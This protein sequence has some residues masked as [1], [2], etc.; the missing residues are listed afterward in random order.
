MTITSAHSG[1]A[2]S[3]EA[4]AELLQRL[5]GAAPKV[6]VFFAGVAHDGAVL[7]RALEQRF[8]D[9][10]VIGCSTNGEFATNHFGK[11]GAVALAIGAGRIG[12]VASVMA[13]VSGD[14]EA[15]FRQAASSL[16]SKLG[17]SIR[18]LEPN[19]YAAIALLE[20][21]RGREERI[22]AALGDVAPFLPFIGGSAGD[23][24]TFTGTWV[25]AN[26]RL[27]RDGTALLIAEMK[28]PFHVLKAC[29]FTSTDRSVTV[30]R[31]DETKRLIL[32]LDGQPA[33][34]F[35]AKAIGVEP[36]KL[37][38]AHFLAHPLG[39]MVDGEP[40]L[41]SGVRREGEALFFACAVAEG[42]K[43]H[44]MRGENLVDD[45]RTRLAAVRAALAAPLAG[46]LF[47][48][49]AYRMLEAQISG[50]EAAYHSTLSESVVHAGMHSNGE[51]YLGHINQTLTG[52][53]FA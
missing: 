12:A 51:T 3:G 44:F 15:S 39:L 28:T 33:A 41:R 47:F 42:S 18:E 34:T 4:A 1:K 13:D 11:K 6:V 21:A 30:T 26:G 17:R 31:S 50:T 16:S 37:E 52:L 36:E 49:C 48:N 2:D 9:A 7:G 35:Y 24:I 45:T 40:W 25:W 8:P 23:E 14:I 10:A 20:G 38:F 32:E 19:R 22:N 5:D 27:E 29:H 53:V 46:G 43:L